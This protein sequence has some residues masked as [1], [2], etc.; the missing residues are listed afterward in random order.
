MVDV[1]KPVE[2]PALLRAMEAFRNGP[3]PETERAFA[4]ALKQSHLLMLL[5][6]PLELENVN[7]AG[8]G[9]MAEGAE[10]QIP[11]LSSSDGSLFLF[12]FTDWEALRTWRKRSL[13]EVST[14]VVTFDE[15][16]AMVLEP[17][18]NYAGLVVNPATW[19]HVIPAKLVAAY[20]G[21]AMPTLLEERTEILLGAPSEVPEGMLEAVVMAVEP[22]PQ[23]KR[24]W[25]LLKHEKKSRERSFLILID[26]EDG[27]YRQICDLIG[28]TAS[29]FVPPGMFVELLPADG[30]LGAEI[31]SKQS[32]LEPFYQSEPL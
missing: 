31:L 4:E 9:T 6:R 19:Q 18:G 11:V 32:N 25:L 2:N 5:E 29:A 21:R 23:V 22:V 1:H 30:G 16:A 14:L 13:A 28:R 27:A 7:E 26:Q 12:G 3:A 24:L 15:L 10:I 17:V 20:S 8:Q